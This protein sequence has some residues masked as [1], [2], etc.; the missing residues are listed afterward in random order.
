MP[1]KERALT[2]LA[3]CVPGGAARGLLNFLRPRFQHHAR[4]VPSVRTQ[5]VD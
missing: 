5:H 4:T 1:I 2:Q 3:P